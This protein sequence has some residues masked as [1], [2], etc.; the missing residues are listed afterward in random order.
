MGAIVSWKNCP[1]C[2]K[3][4]FVPE[5]DWRYRKTAT[6]GK[7]KYRW[8]FCS[9]GCLRTYEANCGADMREES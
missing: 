5:K 7:M 2:G 4:F 3:L 9:W 8:Y 6:V 1:Q